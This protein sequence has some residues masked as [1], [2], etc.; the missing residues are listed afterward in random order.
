MLVCRP[1]VVVAKLQDRDTPEG[2]PGPS[3]CL[4]T[5]KLAQHLKEADFVP[6][7]IL[8]RLARNLRC[9]A[10]RTISDFLAGLHGL[11]TLPKGDADQLATLAVLEGDEPFE[12][13]LLLQ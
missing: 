3:C 1:P 12:P 13:I 10:A 7:Y 11:L 5:Y 8:Y 4:G 2:Y 6:L 9:L